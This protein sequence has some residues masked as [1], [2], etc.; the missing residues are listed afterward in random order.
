MFLQY[1]CPCDKPIMFYRTR[2]HAIDISIQCRT[3][4]NSCHGEKMSLVLVK[5]Q[6]FPSACGSVYVVAEGGRKDD[7]R[8]LSLNRLNSWMFARC[9]LMGRSC[10]STGRER[11]NKWTHKMHSVLLS[12][13]EMRFQHIRKYIFH[14]PSNNVIL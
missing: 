1:S 8:Y 11:L 13:L 6:P 7:T 5:I 10:P 3:K 12:N 2:R 4:Y 9:N 14:K